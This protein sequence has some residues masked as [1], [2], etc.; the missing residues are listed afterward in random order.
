[1]ASPA[2]QLAEIL[3]RA[4]A[5]ALKDAEPELKAIADAGGKTAGTSVF[6][7]VGSLAGI[8]TDVILVGAVLEPGLGEA[9][10]GMKAAEAAAGKFGIGS[11]L[12]Y[13]LGYSVF[14]WLGPFFSPLEQAIAQTFP[15]LPLDPATSARLAARGLVSRD[16]AATEASRSAI[17]AGRFGHL[18]YDALQA[19]SLVE[20]LELFRRGEIDEPQLELILTRN[21]INPD[22]HHHLIR[23]ARVLLSPADLAL[24]NLRG[25]LD[26]AEMLAYAHTLGVI[27]ADM[28]TLVDNTG[29]PPG[30]QELLE[31]YRREFIDR[32]RLERGIRQSRIRNEW[33]DV[34]ERLRFV[35]MT[36]SDAVRAVVENYLTPAQGQAIAEQNGLEPGHFAVL[37]ESWGR[38]LAH[39]EMASLVHRGIASRAQ[40]DQAMRESDIKDKYIN[41]SFDVATRLLSE[42]LIVSA[43]H[44]KAI[45]LQEGSKRLLELGYDKGAVSILLKLGL[46]EQTGAAKELTRAQI[47]T[48]YAEGGFTR[49]EA[50]Q[51]L[52]ALGYS[53]LVAGEE[54]QIIDLQAHAREI[55]AEVAVIRT[56]YLAGAIDAT[57]AETELRQL[58]LTQ[59]QA[60]HDIGVWNREKRR[61]ARSLSE[62]Q[63][64]K[65]AKAGTIHPSEAITLLEAIGYSRANAGVLLNSN[66]VPVAA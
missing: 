6:G 12:G 15:N 7:D 3:R 20:A 59:A 9:V 46:H 33:I 26:E 2:D 54:L 62:T 66:G 35:P 4:I 64:V 18:F 14:T 5:G 56:N 48:L 37:H 32:G 28:Q 24:A 58:G 49:A 23:L 30:P 57:R 21:A 51:H 42:R 16:S 13:M 38:P 40:F 47:T 17:D 36:T 1:V 31:A 19:P 34:V 45:T 44:F 55:R 53:A 10:G 63:I 52:E 25:H 41:Q 50:I 27:D 60:G 61:A 8:I 65:A 22:W 39:M 29:E 11:A 43:I